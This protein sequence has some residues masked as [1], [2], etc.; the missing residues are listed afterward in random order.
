MFQY[1]KELLFVE[2]DIE[3]KKDKK[4]STTRKVCYENRIN[5]FKDHIKNKE[6]NP[7]SYENVDVN[8]DKLLSVY[9]TVNPLDTFYQIGFGKSYNEYWTDYNKTYA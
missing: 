2:F 7:K 9:Q 6:E 3:K 4:K 8:F 5:F 1:T